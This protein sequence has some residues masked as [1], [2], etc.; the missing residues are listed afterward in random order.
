MVCMESGGAGVPAPSL[1]RTTPPHGGC[2]FSLTRL[3]ACGGDSNRLLVL[4]VPHC[5]A[6]LRSYGGTSNRLIVLVL[7]V[8]HCFATLR[9]T[10]G[11][12]NRLIVLVLLVPRCFAT[13]RWHLKSQTALVLLVPRCFTALHWRRSK[14][15]VSDSASKNIRR[16]SDCFSKDTR[17]LSEP[18]IS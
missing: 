7:L 17:R 18:H 4:M 3:A 5:F 11:T 13:L 2:A 8:P 10:G 9:S 14:L 16:L 1:N 12:S 6:T 15:Q